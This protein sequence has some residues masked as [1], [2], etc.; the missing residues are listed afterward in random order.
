MFIIY[1][2][3]F[4][5]G[6]YE[7]AFLNEHVRI[8]TSEICKPWAWAEDLKPQKSMGRDADLFEQAHYRGVA[9]P[10]QVTRLGT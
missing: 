4:K 8:L 3:A 5:D 1:L 2:L 7:A 6:I 9:F 10:S